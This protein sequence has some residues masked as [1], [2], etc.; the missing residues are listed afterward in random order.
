V[1][2]FLAR[3][4]LGGSQRWRLVPANA[5]GQLAFGHY[6]WDPGRTHFAPHGISVL[7]VRDAQVAEITAFLDPRMFAP[8]GLSDR[9]QADR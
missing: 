5:N 7:T 4:V 8:F 3:R 6:L 2:R 1:G 9:H